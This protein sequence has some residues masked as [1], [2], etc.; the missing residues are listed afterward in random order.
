MGRSSSTTP[1]GLNPSY[2]VKRL[3]LCSP[4]HAHTHGPSQSPFS[5]LL[6]LFD[7]PAAR[8]GLQLSSPPTSHRV[9]VPGWRESPFCWAHNN[10]PPATKLVA[11][12]PYAPPRSEPVLAL[13]DDVVVCHPPSSPPGP[14]LSFPPQEDRVSRPPS[15]LDL[16]PSKA[17]RHGL[18]LVSCADQRHHHHHHCLHQGVAILTTTTSAIL[19]PPQHPP[20]PT[21]HVARRRHMALQCRQQAA[22]HG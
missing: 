1:Y 2:S 5:H 18:T 7:I 16:N 17:W 3:A 6:P 14:D 20:T 22:L 11:R 9:S 4:S 12:I 10:G 15:D 19:H 8:P 13:S 21:H